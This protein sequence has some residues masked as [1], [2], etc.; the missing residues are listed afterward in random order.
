[1][2]NISKGAAVCSPITDKEGESHYEFGV[3]GRIK[4]DSVFIQFR[5]CTSWIQLRKVEP[6]DVHSNRHRE[7]DRQNKL[8][9]D[10]VDE[11]T[12]LLKGESL[13]SAY[14]IVAKHLG[15]HYF[16]LRVKY[17]HLGD[18]MQKMCLCNRLRSHFRRQ[19]S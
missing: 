4:D 2:G 10:D 9:G 5:D 18:A 3:V 1:M 19:K 15:I 16:E 11:V 6:L 12:K 13:Q 17:D 14:R 7:I 8:E